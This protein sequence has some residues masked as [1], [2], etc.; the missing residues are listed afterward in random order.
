MSKTADW[1]SKA[2]A[3]IIYDEGTFSETNE[4]IHMFILDSSEGDTLFGD[5]FDNQ[6]GEQETSAP[7]TET[8]S[9]KNESKMAVAESV[10][11]IKIPHD[12]HSFF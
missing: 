2:R 1:Q 12:Q 8:K 5:L 9:W 10:G 4:L 3:K 7:E 6:T 11:R